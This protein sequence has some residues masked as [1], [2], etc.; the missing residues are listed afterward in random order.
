[1]QLYHEKIYL[2]K[3]N[4]VRQVEINITKYVFHFKLLKAPHVKVR[5]LILKLKMLNSRDFKNKAE[6]TCFAS[7]YK[8]IINFSTAYQKFAVS[9]QVKTQR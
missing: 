2:L 3:G 5:L 7:Y 1:M 8:T 6:F 9:N 4:I